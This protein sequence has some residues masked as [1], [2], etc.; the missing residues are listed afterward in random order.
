[1]QAFPEAEGPE[2]VPAEQAIARSTTV[3]LALAP[4]RYRCRGLD[5]H[6]RPVWQRSLQVRP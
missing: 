6:D 1:M 5:E 2:A 4:G 3:E